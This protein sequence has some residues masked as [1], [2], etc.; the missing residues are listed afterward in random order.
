MKALRHL[1]AAIAGVLLACLSA[2]AQTDSTAYYHPSGPALSGPLVSSATAMETAWDLVRDPFIDSV[3]GGTE[4]AALVRQGFRLFTQTKQ[5]ASRFAGNDLSCGDC[6]LNGGQRELALPL[7][8]VAGVF[9]EYNKRAGREFSLRDRITG[10]F[11]RSMNGT[12]APAMMSAHAGGGENPDTADAERLASGIASSEEVGALGAYI[13]WLSEGHP[14]GTELP[15]RGLNVIPDSAL[16]PVAQLDSSR[17]RA[18]FL[19]KCVTC[20][21]EDG[22]GIEIGDIK[23]GPLWGP[24]S[25]NDGAGAARVYTLAGMI[26]HDM[27]YLDPGSLTDEEALQVAF[28]ICSQP[29]PVFPFKSGDYR[30]GRVPPDAVY[31]PGVK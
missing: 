19:E 13:E 11:L 7:V 28:Y 29:R 16:I 20:H 26:R 6:H 23:A 12:G 14:A 2:S 18:L 25:W 21:G 31:Y 15:W 4:R 5:Y 22:Q 17:G 1:P 8:G 3:A 10:C 24:G 9:P 27:P 30:K